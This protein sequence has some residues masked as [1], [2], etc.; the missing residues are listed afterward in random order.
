MHLGCEKYV[1]ELSFEHIGI[2]MTQQD[3]LHI[4]VDMHDSRLTRNKHIKNTSSETHEMR[5]GSWKTI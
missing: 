1:T 4:V 5:N 2:V 3:I